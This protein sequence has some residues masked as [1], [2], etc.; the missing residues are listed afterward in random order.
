M[1]DELATDTQRLPAITGFFERLVAA[2][3]TGEPGSRLKITWLLPLAERIGFA[4]WA[5]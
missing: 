2:R 5:C 1:F 4:G 3:C